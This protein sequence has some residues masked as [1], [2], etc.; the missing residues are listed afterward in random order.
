[1]M[2]LGRG[3]PL[4]LFIAAITAMQPSATVAQTLSNLRPLVFFWAVN[5]DSLAK[6]PLGTGFILTQAGDVM[7]AKS[8]VVA[9]TS[10]ERLVVT[11]GSKSAFPVEV[12]MMDVDCA[13]T[14][15]FC[16]ARVP[17]DAV[18]DAEIDEY[19]NVGCYL[20]VPGTSVVIA[21][22]PTD[23]GM[24]V[25]VLTPSGEVVGKPMSGGALPTSALV[26][27]GMEG[28]PAFDIDE[29]VFGLVSRSPT[30]FGRVQPLR[31]ARSELWDRGIECLPAPG[32]DK[33]P[34][35]V[36]YA[37]LV[38]KF[39]ALDANWNAETLS[40]AKNALVD[41]NLDAARQ[42]IAQ[43]EKE[44]QQQLTDAR[45]QNAT[46]IDALRDAGVEPGGVFEQ[47]KKW[48]QSSIRICFLD[49]DTAVQRH[50]VRVAR[51]WSLYGNI[52]LDF[53]EGNSIRGCVNGDGSDVRITLEQSRA[54]SY[55]GTDSLKALDGRP[56]LSIPAKNFTS[57]N[58]SLDRVIL[59]EFGHMLGLLHTYQHPAFCREELDIDFLAERNGW[60][61]ETIDQVFKRS[62][63]GAALVG[64]YD[65][66]SIMQFDLPAKAFLTGME[67]KCYQ[68]LRD[69]QDLSA[70]DILAISMAYP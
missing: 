22:F 68:D 7:T 52:E 38:D 66:A 30:T 17:A 9:L 14:Q 8:N 51:T 67:S 43:L 4:V 47:G 20:P 12:D 15:D 46:L 5:K 45:R 44:A 69:R 58:G 64:G 56:T 33:S 37:D 59:H 13:K 55:I 10:N 41:G 53:G 26:D 57:P 62:Q 3:V 24:A 50:S 28:G 54:W 25:G 6:R 11:I 70:M 40:A 16:F 48:D 35:N 31:R 19:F 32:R 29:V 36:A 21:G 18:A 63:G 60:S 65:A 2:M 49:G 39:A 27:P 23:G 34:E 1:M 42:E 61:R